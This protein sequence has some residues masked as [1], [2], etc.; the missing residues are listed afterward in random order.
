MARNPNSFQA[1]RRT[2]WR[3]TV[4]LFV[5]FGLAGGWILLWQYASGKAAETLEGWRAR[6]AREGR[7][8]SCGTQT[9]AGFPFRIE[10]NC[11]RATAVLRNNKPPF[12]LKLANI[13]VAAEI[14]RP[15]VLTSE[16]ASPLTV[17]EPGGM[18]R[19]VANW[20]H[21]Q[22]TV[23]GTP[24]SPEQVS[25]VFD[26]PRLDRVESS[27][28]QPVIAAGR[29][30]LV[31]RM[32]EGSAR[33]NP[34]IELVLRSNKLSA[35]GLN[36]AAAAGVDSDVDI[37]LRGLKDFSPKPWPE[38]FREIQAAN[39]RIEIRKLRLQQSDTL[40]VGSGT[41]SL[42]PQGRLQGQVNV[43]IAGLEPFLKRIGADK[44]VQSSRTVERLAGTLDRFLPGLG[45]IARQQAGANLGAGI[46]MLGEQTMLEGRHAVKLPLR[47]DDGTMM[48]GPIPVGI[49]PALF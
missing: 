4:L 45:D 47:I 19:F 41:L 36:P 30:A 20:R 24:A 48:L 26:N 10:V 42:N 29:I 6:E 23:R 17:S 32:L 31:G 11:D 21:A 22:T 15:T 16:Y 46:N 25:M 37:V 28:N 13:L 12:E 5:V 35:P 39:G 2:G 40:A 9:I 49:A 43:T 8:Y 14:Y 34:V 3:Y 27:G 7:V 38:R 18:A 44:M 33:S 1:R